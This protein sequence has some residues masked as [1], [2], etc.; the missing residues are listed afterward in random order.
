MPSAGS[1]LAST[2]FRWFRDRFR[3]SR[4]PSDG[5]SRGSSDGASHGPSH[6]RS[7][8][9]A[10]GLIVGLVG[11]AAIGVVASTLTLGADPENETV[12]VTRPA[13]GSLRVLF[14][15]DSITYGLSAE[16][17]DLGYR[18]LMV[19]A[20]SAGGPVTELRANRAGADTGVVSG[21]LNAPANLDLAIIEL[22]TNDVV[23]KTPLPRFETVYGALLD[24]IRHES[25]AVP[26]LCVGTW[27]SEGGADGS[28]AY[29]AV[30][31]DE[32]GER[33]GA[34]VS[35]YGLY[36]VEANRGPAGRDVFGGTSDNFHPN[37]RGYRAI[38]ELLLARISVD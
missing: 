38:A 1:T 17:K 26:L 37:D 28:D 12:R 3:P 2:V 34:F 6:G 27:G 4:G 33:G 30:I 31:E 15:G 9:I 29:N 22:G 32:C 19:D 14:A 36:P 13:E 20:L 21:I 35:L 18:P 10:L 11:L 16:D 25:P 7:R 5:A 23:E 24:R 8:R